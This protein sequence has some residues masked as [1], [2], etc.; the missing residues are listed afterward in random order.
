MLPPLDAEW[1][2][3]DG[4]GGFAMGTVGGFRTRRYHAL[5]LSALTPPTGRMVLVAGVEAWCGG[6][7]L[8][9]HHYAP[10]VRYP[11]GARSLTH[12]STTPWPTWR[13]SAGGAE[14]EHSIV[15]ER[16][17]GAVVLRWSV[18][19]GDP[20]PISVRPLL[21]SRDYHALCH[22]HP[23]RL[24]ASGQGGCVAWRMDG[25]PGFAGLSNG[26]YAAD[27]LWFRNFLL[28]VERDRGM[29]CVED[30]FSP[31]VFTFAGPDAA[32][33]FREGNG[34]VVAAGAHAAI[35]TRA[36]RERRAEMPEPWT[37][38]ADAYVV[39]RGEGRTILAGF[40]WFTD[41]GRDTFIALRGLLIGT[42]RLRESAEVLLAWAGCVDGGM[43]PNRF[44]DRGTE[45][46]FNSVDAALWFCVAV[47]DHLAAGGDGRETLQAAVERIIEG[48]IAGTR[49]GI[50]VDPDGLV[51]A[52]AP[53]VQ[54]TWMDAK[55]GDWVVTPRRGKPVEIQALWINALRI[56]AGW[57]A[58]W[59]SLERQATASL[60][61]LFPDPDTGGLVDV[62]GPDGVPDRA[63]RPNQIFAVGGL[64]F[65]VLEGAAA[66]AVVALVE[67]RLLTPM[68]LRTL[69]PADPAY[70]GLYRGGLLERDGA[71]HQG[72]VWPWLMG[73]FVEAALRTRGPAAIP[74]LRAQCL[75]PLLAHAGQFGL[76]HV[77]EVADGTAPYHPGGCP[78]QAWSMGELIRIQRMLA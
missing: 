59:G 47:H 50:G 25:G 46:E 8:S 67:A 55:C 11:D 5:L 14:I 53:G 31:G 73:P 19:S 27:P 32:L 17:S 35:L 70:Q 69:D 41:W 42:G 26:A 37:L 43:L 22:E 20:G 78:F 66:V 30:L 15:V 29:E 64:P 38:A 75:T 71:Y 65:A 48:T 2:E 45:P 49:Y 40:P 60:L 1:L 44:P 52:G 34:T 61:A 36:E 51:R 4:L 21:A 9:T 24:E 10:D 54:L 68:G 76:G 6:I 28:T 63:V 18:L 12:F 16:S 56:A 33:I 13:F 72:T 62:I 58:Q 23:V 74:A 77:S 7:P 39:K 3:P 57:T